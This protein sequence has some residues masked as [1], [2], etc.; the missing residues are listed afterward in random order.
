MQD[1]EIKKD[2]TTPIT[3]EVS[4]TEITE[5]RDGAEAHVEKIVVTGAHVAGEDT[6]FEI[7]TEESE[8]SEEVAGEEIK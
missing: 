1:E 3:V 2:E 5:T 7:V 4:E 8:E 6:K